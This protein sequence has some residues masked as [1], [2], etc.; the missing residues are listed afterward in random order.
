[1]KMATVKKATK[2]AP[3]LNCTNPALVPDNPQLSTPMQIGPNVAQPMPCHSK[4]TCSGSQS[5]AATN[6]APK[7]IQ[8][9]QEPSLWLVHERLAPELE[10][11]AWAVVTC[12]W[13]ADTTG[14]GTP[15]P[16]GMIQ[17]W[18]T[19][20]HSSLYLMSS[21]WSVSCSLFNT[22]SKDTQD[23]GW[24]KQ[25]SSGGSKPPWSSWSCNVWKRC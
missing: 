6:L 19:C 10:C 8:K 24:Y 9:H 16:L 25:S 21:Y 23:S 22:T 15:T 14:L 18:H 1:M 17:Q 13:A 3:A 12:S 11:L 2:T 7:V 5:A 4:K 20:H